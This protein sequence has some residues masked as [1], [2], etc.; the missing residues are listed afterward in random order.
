MENRQSPPEHNL[1]DAFREDHAVLGRGFHELSQ[2]LRGADAAGAREAAERIDTT[3]G[4]HIAFEEKHFYPALAHMLGS[5]EVR[6]LYSEH[7]KGLEAVRALLEHEPGAPLPEDERTR[8]MELSRAMEAHIAEC[9][10]MFA[11]M[12]RLPE[13]D[14]AALYRELTVWRERHPRW[15]GLAKSG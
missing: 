14:Q 6:R 1:F 13:E 12:E 8:L 7:G 10:E 2:C 4:A 5:T 11:A 15:T 9:G 3:A